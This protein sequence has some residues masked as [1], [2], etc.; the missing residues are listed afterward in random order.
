LSSIQQA[1]RWTPRTERALS[2]VSIGFYRD[3]CCDELP[4]C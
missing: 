3:L 2:F 4:V 1:L